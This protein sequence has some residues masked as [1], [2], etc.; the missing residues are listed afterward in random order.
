MFQ[1]ESN[2]PITYLA[3]DGDGSMSVTLMK[4]SDTNPYNDPPPTVI[5]A[6]EEYND[7]T[8]S[9]DILPRPWETGISDVGDWFVLAKGSDEERTRYFYWPKRITINASPTPT[10]QPSENEKWKIYR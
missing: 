3:Q 6:T 5:R 4:D 2:I 8:G 10:P 7:L 9:F 1:V